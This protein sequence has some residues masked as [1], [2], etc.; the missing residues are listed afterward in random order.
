[1]HTCGNTLRMKLSAN[2]MFFVC[3]CFDLTV[4]KNWKFGTIFW[5][6]P[7]MH[8]CIKYCSMYFMGGQ[9]KDQWSQSSLIKKTN[10][11]DFNQLIIWITITKSFGWQ[12]NWSMYK[13][14]NLVERE[15]SD[16]LN[17]ICPTARCADLLNLKS[18]T[19]KLNF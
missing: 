8:Y 6:F 17:R 19:F 7:L 3:W 11:V 13:T 9:H 15:K 1:M 10:Y 14:K 16:I 18:I 5:R 4:K 12:H 2:I